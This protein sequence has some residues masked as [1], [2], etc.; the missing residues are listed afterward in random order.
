M[1]SF[2]EVKHHLQ[3]WGFTYLGCA[4]IADSRTYFFVK[5]IGDGK[6]E[7]A[8][9]EDWLGDWTPRFRKVDEETLKRI[10]ARI[11]KVW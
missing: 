11:D 7:I 4:D 5:K 3:D 10:K 8:I 6:Y 9:V 2:R 1:R